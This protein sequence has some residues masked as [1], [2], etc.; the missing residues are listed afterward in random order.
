MKS[1]SNC[2]T[3]LVLFTCIITTKSQTS[4]VHNSPPLNEAEPSSVGVSRERL[5][6]IDAMCQESVKDGDVP[7]II[8][9]TAVMMLWEEGKFRLD[10]PV[11][12][13]ITE[14]R[15]PMVMKTFTYSD[16][17]YTAIPAIFY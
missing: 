8:T 16:T 12:K 2:V 9:S 15:D 13:Y 11:S 6:R 1:L 14:F 4:S 17:T 10:D 7:G 5:D 3:I